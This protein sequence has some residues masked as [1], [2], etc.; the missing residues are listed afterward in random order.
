M[1]DM[2]N[3]IH[4]GAEVIACVLSTGQQSEWTKFRQFISDTVLKE[5]RAAVQK[6]QCPRQAEVV[7]G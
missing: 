4:L 5:K 2:D 3:P 6:G 7:G 1:K